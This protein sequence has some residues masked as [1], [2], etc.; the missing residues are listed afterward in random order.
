MNFNHNDY[1]NS[2]TRDELDDFLRKLG[3]SIE[4]RYEYDIL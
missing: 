1:Q 4:S 2:E 3:Y